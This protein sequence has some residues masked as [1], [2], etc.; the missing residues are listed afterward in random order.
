MPDWQVGLWASAGKTAID[1]LGQLSNSLWGLSAVVHFIIGHE[2]EIAF[3]ALEKEQLL[4]GFGLPAESA[5]C[6]F[7]G[8]EL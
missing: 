5:S 3:P 2:S 4:V 1:G 7:Q 6:F 8:G